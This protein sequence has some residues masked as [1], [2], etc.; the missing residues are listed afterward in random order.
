MRAKEVGSDGY[1]PLCESGRSGC[2]AGVAVMEPADL[3]VCDD[4]DQF[5]RLNRAADRRLTYLSRGD[6]PIMPVPD[7]PMNSSRTGFASSSAGAS[8]SPCGD[9]RKTFDAA[10]KYAA[11][12]P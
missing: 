9:R 4:F 8:P 7:P 12:D 1:R 11:F 5:G 3:W 2:A 6:A 10:A